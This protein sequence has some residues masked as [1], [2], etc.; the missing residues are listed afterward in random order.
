MY[1]ALPLNIPSPDNTFSD[2]PGKENERRRKLATNFNVNKILKEI[3]DT[4]EDDQHEDIDE[5]DPFSD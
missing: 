4:D 5:L 1:N 3:L 2:K